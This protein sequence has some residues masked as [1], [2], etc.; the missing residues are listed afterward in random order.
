MPFGWPC[1]AQPTGWCSAHPEGS[2][3]LGTAHLRAP[4]QIAAL[5]HLMELLARLGRRASRPLAA[6][7]GRGLLAEGGTRLLGQ[8]GDR[9]LLLGRA[10]GLSHVAL[11]GLD[12][13]LGS[14]VG[15]LLSAAVHLPQGGPS[16]PW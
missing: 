4:R 14:H 9:P 6:G 2:G 8:M 3:Q 7:D 5:G 13:T 1:A 16:L 11:G 15:T 10:D 12:L